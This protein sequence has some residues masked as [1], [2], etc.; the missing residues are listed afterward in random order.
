MLIGSYQHNMDLKGR[1]TTP[2]KFREDLGDKFY[3]C[4]GLN[5]CLLVYSEQGFT[6]LMEKVSEKAM[7]SAGDIQRFLLSGATEVEPD[8]Q[9]RILIPQNLREH[10]GIEKEVT[11]IGVG[12]RAEMWNTEKLEEYN[13]VQ[14]SE[15]EIKK[16][17]MELGI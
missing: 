16:A 13:R 15:A 12:T 9:G 1:V 2:S 4:K 14:Q 5:S 17:M 3:V 10:A 8:K 7:S 6:A 11:I